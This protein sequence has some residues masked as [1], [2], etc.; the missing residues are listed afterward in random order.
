MQKIQ[1]SRRTAVLGSIAAAVTLKLPTAAMAQDDQA[2]AQGVT[3]VRRI[4]RF[5]TYDGPAA[6]V[7]GGFPLPSEL[8]WQVL[9]FETPET[10]EKAF[11]PFV[12]AINDNEGIQD[13]FGKKSI[14]LASGEDFLIGDEV[15][16]IAQADEA[17]EVAEADPAGTDTVVLIFRKGAYLHFGHVTVA[18]AS[19]GDVTWAVGEQQVER[20]EAPEP[21]AV[22]ADGYHTG[23]LWN[24]LPTLEDVEPMA[25]MGD[26]DGVGAEMI[27]LS[28]YLYPATE[29]TPT[30]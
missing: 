23:G 28:D 2:W 6:T 18:G 4:G 7:G 15:M 19:A 30:V 5:F 21:E 25:F 3:V 1:I 11:K 29:G 24:L 12:Q 14:V 16:M 9:V 20:E 22:D 13:R 10:L 27:P 8:S 17:G 26:D